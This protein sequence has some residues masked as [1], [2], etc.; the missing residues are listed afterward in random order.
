MKYTTHATPANMVM[1]S[2]PSD[3]G[4]LIAFEGLDGSGK[5]TQRKLFKSWLRNIG[6]DV[7]VTK[8][9]SSPSFK[10]IIKSRKAA[11]S[12]DPMSYA[13]LHAADFWH[14]HEM[15]IEPSLR[16]A[17]VVLADRYV[18][19]GLARDAARGVD[20]DWGRSLYSGARKPNLVFYF[21]APA[22]TCAARIASS[23]EISFYESGQDVTALGDPFKSF[24]RFGESVRSEYGKLNNHFG[25]VNVNASLPIYEQH[26]FLRDTYVQLFGLPAEESPCPSQL[27]AFL[28]EVDV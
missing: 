9:N 28:S 24:L 1:L 27:S 15:L 5:T 22:N 13:A 14:R 7:V 23:R 25:F 10:S 2:N 11:R 12:L 17:K 18:F 6:G 19:T 26:H 8:W 3:R 20:R 16:E 21:D 4:V